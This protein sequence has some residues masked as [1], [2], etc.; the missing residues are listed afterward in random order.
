MTDNTDLE[1]NDRYSQENIGLAGIDGVKHRLASDNIQAQISALSDALN[2]GDPGLDLVIDALQNNYQEIRN[3]AVNILRDS[4]IERAER[5]LLDY[6]PRSLFRQFDNWNLKEFNLE[7]YLDDPVDTAYRIDLKQFNEIISELQQIEP[8]GSKI[9]ALY[10]P[11]WYGY[12]YGIPKSVSYTECINYLLDAHQQLINLKALFFADE[13]EDRGERR[14]RYKRY[15]IDMDEV[16]YLLEAYPKLEVLHL[17]G[18]D[19]LKFSHIRHNNLKTLIIESRK[20]SYQTWKQIFTLDLPQLE[21]LELWIGEDWDYLWQKNSDEDSYNTDFLM[22]I[23]ENNWFP[24]LKYL[25][26]CSCE[27]VDT[28]VDFLEKFPV[29]QRLKILNLSYGSLTDKGAELLLNCPAID[30]LHTIN[31]SMNI[32]SSEMLNKL[33]Q[34]LRCNIIL[35][36][37][38]RERIGQKCGC[39]RYSSLYE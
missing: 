34:K 16:S 11:M 36:P 30:R 21:Y 18:R 13:T 25:G 9:E 8:Q 2:Y 20:L 19:D 32:L 5:A 14:W 15:K 33:S 22:S 12:G 28:L 6:D 39:S 31:I 10:C 26:L 27:G 37:Q 35:Q 38:D 24:N 17:Q 7:S 4:Q 1:N 23:S 3:L 29:I